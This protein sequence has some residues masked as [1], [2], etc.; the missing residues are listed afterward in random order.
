MC[1]CMSNVKFSNPNYVSKADGGD[2]AGSS[3]ASAVPFTCRC[4]CFSLTNFTIFWPF[5]VHCV[6]FLLFSYFIFS[7]CTF[8]SSSSSV[9]LSPLLSSWSDAMLA[10]PSFALALLAP[11]AFRSVDNGKII[12]TFLIL[13]TQYLY[14]RI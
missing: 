10:S 9:H 4:Q 12:V 5:I 3:G 8:L 6:T 13:M 7:H 11:N 1:V 14:L 2:L